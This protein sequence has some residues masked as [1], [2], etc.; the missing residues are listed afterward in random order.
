[1]VKSLISVND[2]RVYFVPHM[3]CERLKVNRKGV[4]HCQSILIHLLGGNR[5]CDTV[6][7]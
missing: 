7:M 2:K 6:I 3:I 1:M 5:N 4:E